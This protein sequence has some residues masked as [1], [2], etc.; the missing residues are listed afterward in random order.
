MKMDARYNLMYPLERMQDFDPSRYLGV[1]HELASI[2]QLYERACDSA[3]AEYSLQ[4][5]VLRV[6]NYCLH[7]GRVISSITGTAVVDP[8]Y[9]LP[10]KL[11]VQFSPG[12]Q[13]EYWVLLTDYETFSIV[14][15]RDGSSLWLLSR[16]RDAEADFRVYL[17]LLCRRLGLDTGSL[18]WR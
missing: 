2:P 1:W 14:G 4:G 12:M 7:E 6:K 11:L 18:Q 9:C 13:G 8:E 3:I 16:S 10:S 15:N 5:E 17:F